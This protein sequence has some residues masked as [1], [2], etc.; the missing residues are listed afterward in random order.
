[1]EIIH[2]AIVPKDTMEVD[3]Q[4][5]QVLFSCIKNCAELI[6]FTDINECLGQ[7]CDTLTN[8]TNLPGSFNCTPCPTGYTGNGI[9]G[10]RR[11]T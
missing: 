7:P 3:I 2:A 5:V 6:F 11:T 4:A 9:D 8:C 1:M 10:C